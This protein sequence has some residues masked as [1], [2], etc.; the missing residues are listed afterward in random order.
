MARWGAKRSRRSTGPPTPSC[1][2]ATES[3]TAP[4]SAR[5][6]PPA[7]PSSGGGR[8]TCRTWPTT[9]ARASCSGRAT[10]RA[11]RPRSSGWPRTSTTDNEWPRPLFNGA[12][13]CR[14][15]TTRRGGSSGCSATWRT[16]RGV[17]LG[18]S[19]LLRRELPDVSV[20][21]PEVQPCQ[22]PAALD[23]A[24][25]VDTGRLELGA[26]RRDVV[27]REAHH[28]TGGEVAVVGFVGGEDL[29]GVA[30][31][32]RE[33]GDAGLVVTTTQAQPVLEHLRGLG[34]PI[35]T[36]ADPRNPLNVHPGLLSSEVAR[37]TSRPPR[38]SSTRWPSPA[39]PTS[40]RS[41]NARH[42]AA[43]P[44]RHT[45]PGSDHAREGNPVNPDP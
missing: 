6:W 9:T 32:E 37:G 2:P 22:T 13:G 41:R 18:P 43:S 8:A 40:S 15:G 31:V 38:P 45:A 17:D 44:P 12:A 39:S 10:S 23:R 24:Q 27:D 25:H 16:P 14:P 3:P 26:G 30:V 4:S 33:H 36:G 19:R 7:S 11:L 1:Y 5:R 42:T 29:V 21:A 34:P 20:G 35:R 28:G